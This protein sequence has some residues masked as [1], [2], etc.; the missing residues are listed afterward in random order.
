MTTDL[1]LP[2]AEMIDY[3]GSGSNLET[4]QNIGWHFLD[5]FKAAGLKPHH[6]VL[7]VGCGIGRMARPLTTYLNGKGSYEGFDIVPTGI[8]WCRKNITPRY[9]NFHFQLADIW[10]DFYHPGGRHR[11]RGYR[12]PFASRSFDFL[13][14]TSVFTHMLP[15][16]LENYLSEAAR[17]LKPGGRCLI[18]FFLHSPQVA[19][20]IR[21]GTG[22]FK[23]PYRVGRP[24]VAIGTDPEYGDCTTETET[25]RERVVAY[26]ERWVFDQFAAR[27]LTVDAPTY[28][29]WSGRNGPSFQDLLTATRTGSPS[30]STS[31]RRW[32]RLTPL[33]EIV[34]RSLRKPYA[35]R[36]AAD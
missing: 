12:F 29:H 3:V 11:A 33:R 18:T 16:D 15:R 32:V 22:A 6:R 4:F 1:V 20:N 35:S 5:H 36:R 28:G 21:N 19:A 7:D 10:N 23:L 9:P 14:L 24:Y 2:P 31:I 26:D 25:E 27:G 34:W 13:Y 30:I 17:V 8:D